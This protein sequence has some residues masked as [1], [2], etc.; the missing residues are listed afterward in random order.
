[1]D[2]PVDDSTAPAVATAPPRTAPAP[3]AEYDLGG[4]GD[5]IHSALLA[6]R[7]YPDEARDLELEGETLVMI[8]VHRDGTLAGRPVVAKSSGHPCLDREALR[9]VTA[10][11]PFAKLPDGYAHPTAEFTIPVQFELAD[12]F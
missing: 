11:A 3:V 12:E 2:V 4:Y 5:G 7:M 8:R 9:M 1:M 6:E 10:A